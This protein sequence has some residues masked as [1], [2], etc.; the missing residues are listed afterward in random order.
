MSKELT[1]L[2]ALEKLKNKPILSTDWDKRKT[3]YDCNKLE[4][5]TIEAALKEVSEEDKVFL[6]HIK[7]GKLHPLTTKCYQDL[8]EKQRALE[9]IIEKKVNVYNFTEFLIKQEWTY[10][11]YLDEENDTSTSGHQFA[12][13][14]LTPE[15]FYLL[16]K[17]LSWE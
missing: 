3:A 13:K 14:L 9:I 10:E 12:Y 1:P 5:D 15:E 11:Q 4:Y 7:S 17:V 16:K 8:L 2:E 6:A